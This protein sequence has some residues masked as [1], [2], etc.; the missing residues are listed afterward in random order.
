VY[1]LIEEE[2]RM[3]HL[4]RNA[5]LTL[6]ALALLAGAA[7]AATL[8]ESF[9]QSYPFSA[10]GTLTLRNVNGSVTLDA[11]DRNEVRIEADK[12]V[13]AGS[14]ADARKIMDQVK[15]DVQ[16]A[17]G[18]LRV[19]TK[20]PKKDNGLLGWLGNNGT[21]VNVTYR[22][23]LPRQAHVD[24]GS[25]NGAVALT[26]THG[27]AKLDSTNGSLKVTGVEGN[28]DLGTTN[29]S[30]AAAGING[31]VKAETTNGSINLEF[32]NVPRQGDLALETTNGG[33]TV[34]LPRGS[35]VSVDAET[36]NGRV[37]SD[38]QVAGGEAGKR[39]LSGDINGGGSRLHIR[40]TNGGVHLVEG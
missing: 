14:D 27:A 37:H 11:W 33:V 36:T 4:L 13:K 22:V 34:K 29:G 17:A 35:G 15:I 19:D 21:N 28:L 32:A 2:T 6:T 39:H 30:I 16:T 24:A 7:R 18:G 25:V 31:T 5:G 23:H 20:L 26:G 9:A 8:K 10:G 3:R 38:F 40:T 12:E 1:E